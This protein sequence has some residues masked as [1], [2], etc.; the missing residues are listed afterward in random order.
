MTSSVSG[1]NPRISEGPNNPTDIDTFPQPKA[2]PAEPP[3]QDCIPEDPNSSLPP[4][5]LGDPLLK[6][7]FQTQLGETLSKPAHDVFETSRKDRKSVV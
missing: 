7:F 3:S 4:A 1:S 5:P 2:A 6:S